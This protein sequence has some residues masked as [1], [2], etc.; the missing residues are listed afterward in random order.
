MQGVM[1]QV[2]YQPVCAASQPSGWLLRYSARM[3]A[4]DSNSCP[5]VIPIAPVRYRMTAWR[6]GSR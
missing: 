5:D 1:T 4:C 6:D 2:L 3:R